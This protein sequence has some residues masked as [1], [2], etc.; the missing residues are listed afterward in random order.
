MVS[1]QVEVSD[2]AL[3]GKFLFM[4]DDII[5]IQTLGEEYTDI[6]QHSS[7]AET[8]PSYRARAGLILLPTFPS[9]V[10]ARWGSVLGNL[11]PRIATILR[12]LPTVFEIFSEIN[13][14]IF[15]L[16]GTYYD[17]AKRLLGVRHVRSASIEHLTLW[18]TI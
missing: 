4:D 10:L 13:L 9:Y 14:A 1:R 18:L 17:V 7:L 16:R 3:A 6:W 8:V 11:E 5:A 12:A 2:F 15:Y